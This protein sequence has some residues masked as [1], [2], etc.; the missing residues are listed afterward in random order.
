MTTPESLYQTS[1]SEQNIKVRRK[2]LKEALSLGT[3]S[4]TI[5]NA[6]F[7]NLGVKD[8]RKYFQNLKTKTVEDCILISQLIQ[9]ISSSDHQLLHTVINDKKILE[10]C[11]VLEPVC[12][13]NVKNLYIRPHIIFLYSIF[14]NIKPNLSVKFFD[15]IDINNDDREYL[16]VIYY[17]VKGQFLEASD[18]VCDPSKNAPISPNILLDI[19][20]QIINID[21]DRAKKVLEILYSIKDKLSA[22]EEEQFCNYVRIVEENVF[23]SEILDLDQG[24]SAPF[25]NWIVK[26]VR[27]SD[28]HNGMKI[29]TGIFEIA[30]KTK[31]TIYL[32]TF[33]QCARAFTLKHRQ[34]TMQTFCTMLNSLYNVF[35]DDMD[36]KMMLV[37]SY[38]EEEDIMPIIEST[39]DFEEAES[40]RCIHLLYNNK[41]MQ[42][43]DLFEELSNEEPLPEVLKYIVAFDCRWEPTLLERIDGLVTQIINAHAEEEYYE[44]INLYISKLFNEYSADHALHVASMIPEEMVSPYLIA[45]VHYRSKDYSEAYNYIVNKRTAISPF[46]PMGSWLIKSAKETDNLENLIEALDEAESIMDKKILMSAQEEANKQ[47]ERTYRYED[48]IDNVNRLDILFCINAK[49]M[50][51]FKIALTSLL[52]N[53]QNIVD[54]LHFH[55]GYDNSVD[56][57][58]LINFLNNFG[59]KY[60]IKNIESDYK[61]EGLK[62]NYGFT[63]D[64]YLDKS[65]YY[66]IFMIDHIV[67]HMPEVNKILYL[68]SDVIV[69]SSILELTNMK[70][71]NPISVLPEDQN[72]V[73]VIKSKGINGIEEYFNSG[74]LLVDCKHE[75][76]KG[77]IKVAIRQSYENSKNL[78]MHDQC[79]LN[80]AFNKKFNKLPVRFNYLI[81]QNQLSLRKPD[82]AILHLSGRTKPWQSDYHDDEFISNL[83]F[84]YKRM[85][86][87]WQKKK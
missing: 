33:L 32:K 19:V 36:L 58:S 85:M 79:A 56:E 75:D 86:Q 57:D 16:K 2:L 59:I 28:Y 30:T 55:V 53:N 39:E 78:I 22:T 48:K 13:S 37:E 46:H 34:V 74:V 72:S 64:H 67:N 70:M 25:A 49:Y 15:K 7:N 82:I 61:T 31:S 69:L 71:E 77:K 1:L 60:N 76:T 40:L 54:S 3:H 44:P 73:A 24:G 63:T 29:T 42:A 21:R 50:D 83:W 9:S 20:S 23:E 80:V 5:H 27:E 41:I 10:A 45:N 68:D 43:I 4:V 62:D 14:I 11:N 35:P 66:R 51:G 26:G 18:I 17:C 6:Y 12:Q 38:E 65:A 8:K 81:H 52:V 47:S 84:S 87:I